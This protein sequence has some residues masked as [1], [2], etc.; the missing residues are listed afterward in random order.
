MNA[1]N[2]LIGWRMKMMTD[3]ERKAIDE[4]I[5]KGANHL[6]KNPRKSYSFENEAY[7]IHFCDKNHYIVKWFRVLW[8]NYYKYPLFNSLEYKKQYLL[9]DLKSGGYEEKLDI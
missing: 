3:F 1:T 4:A 2:R 7:Y 9:K 8:S 5:E 6:H